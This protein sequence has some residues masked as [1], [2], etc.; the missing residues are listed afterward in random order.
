MNLFKQKD[1]F[2][3]K[4]KCNTC[5]HWIDKSDAQ[6]VETTFLNLFSMENPSFEYYCPEHK[7]AY[8]EVCYV[9][10]RRSYFKRLI[11]SEDGT[12]IGFTKI[13]HK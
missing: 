9:G 10:F 7:R 12:P 11:V 4:V 13:K 3:D 1:P 2:E 8:D 6:K 5:K